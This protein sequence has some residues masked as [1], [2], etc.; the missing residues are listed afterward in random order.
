MSKGGRRFTAQQKVAIVGLHLIEKKPLSEVCQEH[1]IEPGTFYRWQK[2]LF[3]HGA[4][5]FEA[6]GSK[7][8]ADQ[9]AKN[10]EI[11]RLQV[12]LQR[13]DEVLAEL[14]PVSTMVRHLTP[15]KLL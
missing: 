11:A 3:D 1:R 5:A 9:S 8:T 2:E 14:M 15:R 7:V 13:Q 6:Q 12:R 4:T 10:Q